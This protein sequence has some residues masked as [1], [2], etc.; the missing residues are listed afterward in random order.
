M[1]NWT[2][3]LNSLCNAYAQW[4]TFGTLKDV[5]EPTGVESEPS[6]LPFEFDLMVQTIERDTQQ[7][8]EE[9]QKVER[10]SVLEGLRKYASEHVLLVGRP[11]LGKSTALVRLLVATAQQALQNPHSQI[12]VLVELR[13]Y[14]IYYKTSVLDVVQASLKR[15]K[16]RLNIETLEDE[17]AQGRFLL[18]MDGINELPDDEARRNIKEFRLDY[19]DVPMDGIHHAGFGR[20]WR[21]WD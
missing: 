10:L 4:W 17:L 11:G 18:L 21:F 6:T 16:L 14:N 3:Y 2:L 13:T 7:R 15:R 19:S 20:G 8:G 9:E 12:P 1:V 5:V